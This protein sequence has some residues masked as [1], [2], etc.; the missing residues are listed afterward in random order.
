MRWVI[1]I[2]A[3]IVGIVLVAV[4]GLAVAIAVDRGQGAERLAPLVNATVPGLTGPDVAAYVAR[5]SGPGPH[6]A[7]IMIHEFWGLRQD[8]V[9]KADLL[10][11]QG[12]IVIAPDLFRGVATDFVPSG[13]YN[14][15]TST[16]ANQNEDLDAVFAWLSA[17]SDVDRQRTAVAGF[18]FGGGAALR[19]SLTN[20]DLAA[21]VIFYGQLVTDS[22][23]LSRLSGPVLGIFGGADPSIPT[24]EVRAFDAALEEAGIAHTITI[25]DGQ[26]HAFVSTVE[27]IQAGGPP[28]DAWVEMVSF[29]DQ[30]LLL[31][32]A[33][34]ESPMPAAGLP[35]ERLLYAWRLAWSHLFAMGS[36][37]GH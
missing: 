10:A 33:S 32:Q 16:T 30:A 34:S 20:A 35:D 24:E 36:G 1:R 22:Q 27:A 31:N 26:P 3:V 11:E 7:V 18:C 17:Q 28:G 25:Y 15:V 4:V 8:V 23:Q 14:V 21:T 29:L 13:I 9:D 5:P 2:V 19:Y 6:P 37:H 12:Y